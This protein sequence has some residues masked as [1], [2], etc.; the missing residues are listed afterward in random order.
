MAMKGDAKLNAKLTRGVKN[1]AKNLVNFLA[2]SRKSENLH[3][4]GLLLYKAYKV[5]VEKVQKIYVS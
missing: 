5:F 2:S 3:F 4:D 1:V